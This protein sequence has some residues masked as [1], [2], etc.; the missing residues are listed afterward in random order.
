MSWP[1]L[2]RMMSAPAASPSTGLI[3]STRAKAIG[4]KSSKLV[5][6]SIGRLRP[7]ASSARD[8]AVVAED[9]ARARAGLDVVAGGAAEDDVVAVAGRDR[10]DAAEGEVDAL[11]QLR[12]ASR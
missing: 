11:D 9:D 10:V 12:C 4:W 6:A 3:V 8:A 7:P 2:V 5:R 1:A